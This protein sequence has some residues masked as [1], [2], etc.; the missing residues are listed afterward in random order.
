MSLN[1]ELAA[2]LPPKSRSAPAG[3]SQAAGAQ[4]RAGGLSALLPPSSSVQLPP[5][6]LG[7]KDHRSETSVRG[8]STVSPPKSKRRPALLSQTRLA[9]DRAV[10]SPDAP[11]GASVVQVLAA[12]EYACTSPR[13]AAPPPAPAWPPKSKRRLP[14]GSQTPAAPKRPGGAVLVGTSCVQA[15]VAGR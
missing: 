7:V 3:G 1:V 5:E 4:S 6:A 10:G 13:K 11:P 14:M 15:P 2:F 12:G 9:R 8:E